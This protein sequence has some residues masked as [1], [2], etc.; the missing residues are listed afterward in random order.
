MTVT[1]RSSEFGTRRWIRRKPRAPPPPSVRELPIRFRR[2]S[3]SDDRRANGAPAETTNGS[4][5]TRATSRIDQR[6][7]DARRPGGGGG[8]QRTAGGRL[9]GLFGGLSAARSALT[10]RRRG[11]H[12]RS[13]TPKRTLRRKRS[14]RRSAAGRRWRLHAPTRLATIRRARRRRNAKPQ[15]R[16]GGRTRAP[17]R[18]SPD[19]LGGSAGAEP[20]YVLRVVTSHQ[21]PHQ[22]TDRL[23]DENVDRSRRN[24]FRSRQPIRT[25]QA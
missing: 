4:V 11:R 25:Q 19:H 23:F 13:N 2:S 16:R 14:P 18:S 22:R 5:A 6:D 12:S 20:P 10:K 7:T 24:Q 21:E 3:G 8:P 15:R 1:A 9:G 17:G